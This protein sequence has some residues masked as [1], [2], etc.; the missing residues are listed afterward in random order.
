VH[1]IVAFLIL[2]Q[3][4][5]CTGDSARHAGLAATRAE[6]F[7]LAGA[8]QAFAAAAAAGCADADVSAHFLKGLVAARAAYEFGGSPE[9]LEPVKAAIA[10]LDARGAAAPGLAQVSRVLLLAAAAAAQSERDQMTLLIDHAIHLESIQIEAGQG[11]TRGVTAH[12][13]AGDLFLQVHRYEDARRY[14]GQAAERVG[15]TPRVRLGLARTATRL[16]DTAAACEQ[17]RALVDAWGSRDE[18]PAEIVEARDAV[19]GPCQPA[20]PRR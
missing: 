7:D 6:A 4:I 10:A 16:G 19:K 15:T 5:V 9:S 1:V 11:G 20:T 12:E 17:Y 13:A 14:Y 8:A 2:A 3:T 18:P